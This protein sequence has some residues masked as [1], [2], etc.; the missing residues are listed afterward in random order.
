MKLIGINYLKKLSY[1]FGWG[2]F[3]TYC[4][5]I[6]YSLVRTVKLPT[7]LTRIYHKIKKVQCTPNITKEG[8]QNSGF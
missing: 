7:V 6:S 1:F 2:Y 4:L 8:C 5:V 3:L